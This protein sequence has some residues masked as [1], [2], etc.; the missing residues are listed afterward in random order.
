M[1]QEPSSSFSSLGAGVQPIFP[2]YLNQRAVFDMVAMLQDGIATVTQVSSRASQS[3]KREDAVSA[4][5][6]LSEALTTLLRVD[7]SGSTK[8]DRQ[9]GTERQSS[10]ERVHTPASLLHR[11]RRELFERGVASRFDGSVAPKAG[12]IIE[13]DSSLRRNPA[14]A[15]MDLLLGLFDLHLA[16]NEPVPVPAKHKGHMKGD[17]NART[18]KQM[19]QF[20]ATLRSGNTVD[21]VSDPL[22]NGFRA[23]I[24]LEEQYLS[25]P[26]MADLVDGYFSVLGKVIRVVA[27]ANGSINLLR[28]TPLAA[29]DDTA[30]TTAFGMFE[31]LGQ[32]APIAVPKIEWA[33]RGPVIHVLPVA[34]FA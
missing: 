22:H 32:M 23:V 16:F 11:L 9:D 14:V 15:V 19:E 20:A 34:V 6:G 26:T 4:R 5:F 24:T 21:I 13:F 8:S 1:V 28:K 3:E 33:I 30:L 10:E 29:I 27:D 2:V 18:R 17:D 12:S 7:L 25:D 31:Q